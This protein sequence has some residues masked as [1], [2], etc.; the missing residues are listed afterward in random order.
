MCLKVGVDDRD[1][2]F[3][4]SKDSFSVVHKYTDIKTQKISPEGKAKVQLQIVLHDDTSTTF[5]FAH[6]DGQAAQVSQESRP[7]AVAE[8]GFPARFPAPSRSGREMVSRKRFCRCCRSSKRRSIRS[9][10]KDIDCS[11]K[12][13]DC[14]SYTRIWYVHVSAPD[15]ASS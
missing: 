8:L 1:I 4:R 15:L 13:R 3:L 6:P 12:T 14:C 11:R 2:S 9:W 5:H 7:N 10:R